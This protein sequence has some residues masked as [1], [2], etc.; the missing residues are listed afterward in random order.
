MRWRINDV[1]YTFVCRDDPTLSLVH[2]VFNLSISVALGPL[3]KELM[4]LFILQI[5][6]ILA[7]RI[8]SVKSIFRFQ[9]HSELIA[10]S[11]KSATSQLREGCIDIQYV[12]FVQLYQLCENI[13]T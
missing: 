9:L 5:L 10:S 12:D 13:Y 2:L 8:Y 4:L 11:S 7:Q 3:Y 1:S 6:R